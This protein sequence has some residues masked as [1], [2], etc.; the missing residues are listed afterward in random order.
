[1]IRPWP[2]I[3]DDIPSSLVATILA[4]GCVGVDV[5]TSGLDPTHDQ[6]LL[7]TTST[8]ESEVTIIRVGRR[9]PS[10]LIEILEAPSVTKIFHHATFDSSFLYA[11]YSVAPVPVYCTKLAS[12]LLAPDGGSHT[13][14][15]LVR[16]HLGVEIDKSLADSDWS[17]QLSHDQL[18]ALADDVQYLIPLRDALDAAF[19][20]DTSGIDK[21]TLHRACRSFVPIAARLRAH[22][23]WPDSRVNTA[24]FDY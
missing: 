24:L 9:H 6:L 17:G 13:L 8:R 12:K 19:E 4:D 1:M 3:R 5:E 14:A 21:Y 15:H 20:S 10:H 18:T 22:G 23:L 7:V 2:S 16:T 11:H